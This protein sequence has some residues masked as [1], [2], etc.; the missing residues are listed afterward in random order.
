MPLGISIEHS[1]FFRYDALWH[2]EIMK[3]GY[4]ATQSGNTLVTHYSLVWPLIMSLA[5]FVLGDDKF[6]MMLL[7][8][9]LFGITAS[10]IAKMSRVAGLPWWKPVAFFCC[11]PTAFFANSVYNEPI[12][13]LATVMSVSFSLEKRALGSGIWASVG[14]AI[15][16]N[17]WAQAAAWML[18]T[19]DWRKN[20]TALITGL[21]AILLASS[22][23]PL[24]IW[25]WRGSPTAH[26]KDLQNV[27]WMAS[28]QMIPF[29]EPV[30]T[31]ALVIEQPSLLSHSI[32]FMF[33]RG[34]SAV[35][36]WASVLVLIF[37]W[38]R[39][40]RVVKLQGLFTIIG[41]GLLEQAISLPRYIMAFV[42]FYF[43]AARLP[44]WALGAVCSLMAWTQLYLATRFVRGFWA[45]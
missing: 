44:P 1:R 25:Y 21:A 11:F 13:M 19:V 36:I 2:W 9:V 27:E 35:A 3:N 5:S 33:Y 22:I 37:S 38:K 18:S 10:A 6:R 12:F 28:P 29:K 15:R 7:N 32:D 20:K 24:A 40:P 23:Q 14:V 26:Y 34:W 45:F 4:A 43:W 41:L 8:C 17:G 16:V 42:P 30:K 31:V 39:L